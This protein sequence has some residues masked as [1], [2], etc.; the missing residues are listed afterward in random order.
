MFVDVHC[1]LEMLENLDSIIKECV[2]K[3]TKK[4]VSASV[5]LNS[6]KKNI[7][8]SKKFNEIECCLG[9]HPSNILLMKEKE[10]SDSIEFLQENLFF[11]KAIGEIGLD[12][13]HADSEEKKQKQIKFYKKQLE[14]VEQNNLPVV[15]H[16]RFAEKKSLEILSSFNGKV[17]LH[18]FDGNKKAFEEGIKKNYFF[19]VGPAILF[20]KDYLQK[21]L[22][23][24]PE[25]LMLETDSPVEFAGK[26]AVPWWV[27]KV[28]EKLSEEK[29]IPLKEI[30]EKTTKNALNFFNLNS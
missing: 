20:N 25:N 23:V 21:T 18:W 17:L 26:K 12:F 27:K 11:A 7:E 2:S 3:G 19:S 29:K 5:D 8:L 28:A 30:E 14:I 1:H 9:L 22:L 4:V 10:I 24:P 6:M 15:V 16:S 13:K